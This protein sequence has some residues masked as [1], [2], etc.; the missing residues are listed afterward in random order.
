MS[1]VFYEKAIFHVDEI[2]AMVGDYIGYLQLHNQSSGV[3]EI[4]TSL[5]QNRFNQK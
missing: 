4:N 2:W 5:A 1:D 3:N